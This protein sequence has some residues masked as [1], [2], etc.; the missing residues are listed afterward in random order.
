MKLHH[1]VLCFVVFF[2]AS[3]ASFNGFYWQ[4][5]FG[6]EGVP[7]ARYPTG[8]EQM[9]N[10]TA[11]RPYVYRQLVPTLANWTDDVAPEFVKA[12]LYSRLTTR[13]GY[14]EYWSQALASSPETVNE[15]YFF[16][17][18]FVY[19]ATFLFALTGTYAMYLVCLAMELP[20]PVA[21]LAPIVLILLIPYFLSYNGKIYDYPEIAFFALA[22]WVT[23]KYKWYWVIPI[24]A[25]GAWNKES[26]LFIVPALY[27]FIRRRHTRTASLIGGSVLILIC[28]VIYLTLRIRYQHNP[29]DPV[30]LEIVDQ[31]RSLL[32]PRA[33]LSGTQE[34]YGL[35]IPRVFSVLP[36]GLL[37]AAVYRS[38]GKFPEAIREHAKI[39]A[40]INI[41][42]Y[43]LFCVPGEM[44]DLSMLYVTLLFVIALNLDD[45][46]RNAGFNTSSA[47]EETT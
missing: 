14:W 28:G 9:V 30:L 1:R 40:L 27:P 43:F 8:F 36:L 25:L 18:C 3:A 33:M 5:H 34:V 22:V 31:I 46:F 11:D 44:R 26:F 4:C 17:Y 38:W 7:R 2:F 42:L 15:R 12:K 32:N 10:G 13:N 47:R 21:V 23:S 37:I 20:L 24:A 41:P 29:G 16:R 35:R 39:A 6:E 45:W 19:F